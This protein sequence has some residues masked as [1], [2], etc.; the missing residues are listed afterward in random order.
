MALHIIVTIK[1]V[2]NTS[3]VTTEAM[4]PDGTVNRAALPAIINPDD[5]QALEVALQLKEQYSGTI[6]VLSMGPP[7]AKEALRECYYRGADRVILLSDRAFAGSDTL[8][9]SFILS[10]A[11]K[12]IGKYDL[13]LCGKQAIDGDTGQVGPQLA[14]K[15]SINQITFV[16]EVVE[17]K[18]GRITAHRLNDSG[19]EILCSPLPILITISS[20][21]ISPRPPNVRRVMAFKNSTFD[22]DA[23]LF[24]LWDREFVG[25]SEESC[26]FKGSPTKVKQIEN[27]ILNTHEMK[28]IPVTQEDIGA[29]IQE[30]RMSH[31]LG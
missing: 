20:N 27:I 17:L 14:E 3:N 22:K 4:K 13:I 6:T 16:S 26:G 18:D 11:I 7:S 1:Q 9:T 12:K 25:L 2:P 21:T 15:L 29:M 30:L 31:F 5:L 8:A 28:Q 24:T 19:Y 10:E 23:P